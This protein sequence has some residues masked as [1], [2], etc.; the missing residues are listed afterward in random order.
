[1]RLEVF[2]ALFP[3]N[4]ASRLHPLTAYHTFECPI[5]LPSVH[6]TLD[7]GIQVGIE[8]SRRVDLT[9]FRI[10]N[11]YC[12]RESI[13]YHINQVNHGIRTPYAG[14]LDFDEALKVLQE[15]FT[16][17]EKPWTATHFYEMQPVRSEHV[18]NPQ[19]TVLQY[20][21]PDWC[22]CDEC[23]R[24]RLAFCGFED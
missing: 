5:H 1:M 13:R 16:S 22:L 18:P 19:A 14:P 2:Y 24:D 9:S 12:S 11:V 10:S 17:S 3:R 8:I 4:N 15:L 21:H 7:L 6:S 23:A 20:P